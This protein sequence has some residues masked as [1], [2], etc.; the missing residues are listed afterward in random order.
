MRVFRTLA[1]GA[2]GYGAYK[3]WK[4]RSARNDTLPPGGA[5]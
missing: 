4:A 5:L 2:I 3:A 1:I